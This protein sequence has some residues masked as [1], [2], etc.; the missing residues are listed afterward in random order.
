MNVQKRDGRIAVYD[1][2]K[3]RGA[4]EKANHAVE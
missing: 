4:I 1:A 2:E 3:I